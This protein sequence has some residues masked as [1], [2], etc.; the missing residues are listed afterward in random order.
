MHIMVTVFCCFLG[1]FINIEQVIYHCHQTINWLLLL[2]AVVAERQLMVCY[3]L[4]LVQRK[5]RVHAHKIVLSPLRQFCLWGQWRTWVGC[6]LSNIHCWI[7]VIVTYRKIS[8]FLHAQHSIMH[9]T[10]I[11]RTYSHYSRNLF[12][13]LYIFMKCKTLNT[14]IILNFL[15]VSQIN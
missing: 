7:I 12:P 11:I 8:S 13:K 2:V 14:K 4:C 15:L 5:L 10:N 3:R 1:N 6:P 9:N